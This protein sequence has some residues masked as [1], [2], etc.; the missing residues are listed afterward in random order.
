MIDKHF[1]AQNLKI[2]KSRQQIAGQT[3]GI[4]YDNREMCPSKMSQN[5]HI[6]IIF[7]FKRI[8]LKRVACLCC[9]LVTVYI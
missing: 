6:F 3:I 1:S 5:A 2:S 7:I 9:V 4:C 8:L